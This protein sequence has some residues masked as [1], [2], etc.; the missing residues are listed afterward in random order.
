[1]P[2]GRIGY[3]A[4]WSRRGAE[5]WTRFGEDGWGTY[6]AEPFFCFSRSSFWAVVYGRFAALGS[7]LCL[8]ATEWNGGWGR[9]WGRW[10]G[11][12]WGRLWGSGSAVVWSGVCAS[13]SASV[14]DL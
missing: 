2:L 7:A 9:W 8:M 3:G 10:W 13:A 14:A 12:L 11:R 1:V 6:R 5:L 4:Y